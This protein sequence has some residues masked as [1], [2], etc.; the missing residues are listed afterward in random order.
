[1]VDGQSLE[2]I[3]SKGSQRSSGSLPLNYFFDESAQRNFIYIVALGAAASLLLA[4]L[5]SV[6]LHP[7]EWVRHGAFLFGMAGFTWAA[8]EARKTGSIARSGS[9]LTLTGVAMTVVPAYFQGG[10]SA[11]FSI[12]FLVIPLVGGLLLGPRMALLTAFLG[13]AAM[14]VLAILESEKMLPSPSAEEQG[15]LLVYLNLVLGISFSGVVGMVCAHSLVSSGQRLHEAME[16]DQLKAVALKESNSRFRASLDAALDAI[17]VV[18]GDNRILDFNPAAEAIFSRSKAD[19]K[20]T[21]LPEMLIPE[22]FREAHVEGFA[23]FQRTGQRRII[24]SK[25][26]TIAVRADGKEF[27]IEMAIQP[28]LLSGK[29]QFAAYIRDLTEQRAA[30]EE[31]RVNN[32]QLAQS[33]RLEAIGRLAG[34]VA[35]DFNNLLTAINGYAELLLNRTDLDESA[36]MG[37]EQVAHAGDQARTLTQQLLAF[38]R[39]D[40]LESELVDPNEMIS[41]LLA[42][43]SRVLSDSI[44]LETRLADDIGLVKTDGARLE[45]A[46]LNL[47]LNAGDAMP[48]G[49]ELTLVTSNVKLEEGE[50]SHFDE[51]SG[52]DYVCVSVRDT[53]TG[54]DSY[55]AGKI[56]EP[57]FTTK[58]IGEGTGLGLATAY[59]TVR[60]SGGAMKVETQPGGGT[61]FK[62]FLPRHDGSASVSVESTTSLEPTHGETLLVVEDQVGVRDLVKNTLEEI[63]YTVIIASDGEEAVERVAEHEGDV[64]LVVTD[65]VMPRLGGPETVRQL[66]VAQPNLKV[67]YVSGYS[68]EDL[69]IDDLAEA[70]TVFLQKPFGLEELCHSVQSL[71][72]SPG[73]PGAENT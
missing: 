9:I 49:G 29:D 6:T 21:Y 63:G 33:R 5:Y 26:E 8:F 59:G 68:E 4:Y 19:V 30:E 64:D 38:S 22:R 31:L 34:G 71:L 28:L 3:K 40:R 51:L 55:T 41:G 72:S 62:I 58:P 61:T 24:G 32:Q 12:W 66:R 27:P 50:L 10:V 45:Q 70:G 42:M 56:F 7:V 1:M 44:I 15:A 57:F 43:M 14:S 37:L 65:V 67:V 20:N 47:V 69:G 39:S 73:G 36:R 17:V 25:V 16:A 53:G 52:G 18:D 48:E 35:H 23:R 2:E 60:Q 54:M 46:L 11:A 13:V